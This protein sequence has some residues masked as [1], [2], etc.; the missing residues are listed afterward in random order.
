MLPQLSV[1]AALPEDTGYVPSTL[2]ATDNHL[3]VQFQR[4]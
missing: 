2:V 4:I 3:S 1:L